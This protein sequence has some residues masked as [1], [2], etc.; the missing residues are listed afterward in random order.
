MAM[1]ALVIFL[2]LSLAAMALLTGRAKNRAVLAPAWLG[3]AGS[4]LIVGAFLTVPW[5]RTGPAGTF[6]RNASWLIDQTVYLD[7]LR[8]L[9]VVQDMVV[10]LK[11]DTVED[12][13]LL[14]DRP[15]AHR[16]LAHV[17]QGGSISAQ[18]LIS[19]ARPVS[20]WL[21][22]VLI[23][24]LLAASLALVASLLSLASPS[25]LGVWLGIGSGI[26]ATTSLVLLL[27]KL[28]FIDTL[29]ATDNFVVRLIAVLGEARVA[30]GGWWMAFGL[31]LLVCA[32]PLY[33]L[34]GRSAAPASDDEAW[35]QTTD[36][37][38]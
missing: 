11:I 37:N 7:F 31:L 8:Q 18:Q 33:L 10:S 3:W 29:G 16:F 6:Q 30:A 36:W 38:G 19:L 27:G 1:I 14:V 26:V 17:E 35:I 25:K 5:A 9:P 24:G 23:A 32:A 22:V 21:P 2:V 28:P 4:L 20:L 13:R 34:F 15:E 12:I